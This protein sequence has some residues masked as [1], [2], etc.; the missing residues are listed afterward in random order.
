MPYNGHMSAPTFFDRWFPLPKTLSPKAAGIDVSDT[1]IKW[2]TIVRESDALRVHSYGSVDLPAGLLEGGL[3]RDAAALSNALRL[4]RTEQGITHAHAALPEEAAFVYSMEVPADSA[5]EQVRSMIEFD[6]EARVP[7]APAAAVYD[8]DIISPRD[9]G[10]RMEIGVAVFPKDVAEAYVSVFRDAGI[11][12]MSLEIEARSIARAVS[13]GPCGAELI[14]DYGSARTGLAVVK[15][16]VPIFTNTALVGGTTITRAIM[17]KLSVSEK[18]AD[19]LKNTQG[20]APASEGPNVSEI[21]AAGVSA[22]GDEVA[23]AYR[24]WD[25]RRDEHGNTMTP[26]SRVVLVGGSASL[27]GVVDYVAGRVQAKTERG[28][29]WQAVCRF[30]DYIPPIDRRASLRYATAVGLALRSV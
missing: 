28:N 16:G 30:D 27:K 15:N 25:T 10:G 24:F 23:R 13:C 17:E 29:V 9:D 12:L 19:V 7:L 20:L 22:L 26:I 1:S 21:A 11:D 8:Y 6:M 14:V 3:I 2:M 4:V 18:D 5:P